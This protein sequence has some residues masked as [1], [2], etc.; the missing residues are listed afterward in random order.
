[1]NDAYG[2]GIVRGQV[3]NM[4]LRAYHQLSRVTAAE[5]I[6]T[7][8]TSRFAGVEY[9][10]VVQKLTDHVL[11]DHATVIAEVDTRHRKFRKITLRD[12]AILYGQRPRVCIDGSTASVWYLS[13]YEFVKYWEVVMV[14]YPHSL[15]DA[16]HS[17][18]H[19]RMTEEGKET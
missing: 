12:S 17:R 7:C 5:A 9:V 16:N 13:P 6:I 8:R 15:K 2:R 14:S 11:P 19:V 4:N 18:H 10:N 3:E 1:M